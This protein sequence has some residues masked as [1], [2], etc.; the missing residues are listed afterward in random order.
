MKVSFLLQ[1]KR[2]I[3]SPSS[4]SGK[5]ESCT[6]QSRAFALSLYIQALQYRS[7]IAPSSFASLYLFKMGDTYRV[8]KPS[9]TNNY[10]TPKTHYNPNRT[11]RFTSYFISH[12]YLIMA[13]QQPHHMSQSTNGVQHIFQPQPH[14]SIPQRSN[15]EG[16]DLGSLT[17]FPPANDLES[18]DGSG[19]GSPVQTASVSSLFPTALG[20]SPL[21]PQMLTTAAMQSMDTGVSSPSNM[22]EMAGPSRPRPVCQSD[23]CKFKT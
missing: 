9:T 21:R 15:G 23:F 2:E 12:L 8:N 6:Y 10:S 5:N 18:T 1:V 13:D 22:P 20:A 19:Y 3:I 4:K 17:G 7:P 16:P 11:R 14:V